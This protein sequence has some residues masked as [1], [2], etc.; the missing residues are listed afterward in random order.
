MG[1][2]T[3]K[4]NIAQYESEWRDRMARHAVSGHKKLLIFG[5]IQ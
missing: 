2:P 5:S 1:K 4:A 3:S